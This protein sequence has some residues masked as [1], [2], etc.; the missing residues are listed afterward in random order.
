LLLLPPY[1]SISAGPLG[2]PGTLS[3]VARLPLVFSLTL[4]VPSHPPALACFFQFFTLW[5]PPFFLGPVPFQILLSA[6]PVVP[7]FELG[8]RPSFFYFSPSTPG[9][10]SF[11]PL[12][13]FLLG[14]RFRESF[15]FAVPLDISIA[16]LFTPLPSNSPRDGK[17]PSDGS[18]LFPRG[19]CNFLPPAPPLLSLGVNFF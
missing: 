19:G 6:Q 5:R 14:P 16:I 10:S 13:H 18:L 1:F 7:F 4:R 2:F 3:A 15:Y 9:H 12:G 11:P 17:A 8:L